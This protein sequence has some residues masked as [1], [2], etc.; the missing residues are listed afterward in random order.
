MVTHADRWHRR[1]RC[2]QYPGLNWYSI[3]PGEVAACRRICASC[4]VRAP[5]LAE[6]F[7]ER[8]PWG[9]WGGLTPDEREQLAGPDHVRILPAHGTNPRYA[10]HRCRC[11]L[12]RAA[13]TAYERNRRHRR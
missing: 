11:T 5:C 4:S 3:E 2:R 12:C 9:V 7:T 10:K 13:H 8:D 1:A 6:A